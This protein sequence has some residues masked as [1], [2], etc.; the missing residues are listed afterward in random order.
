MKRSVLE[1]YNWK[2]ILGFVIPSIL[3]V[4]LFMIPVEVDGTWTVIVK[5]IADLI[6]SCMADFLPI[7]CCI[8]VTISAVLGVAALF[9]PKFIDEHP[10]MYNTF[11]TTPAWVIIRVIGAV[12]AWI[13]FAGVL[14]GDGEPLQIIGGEDTGTFVLGDLLTVLVIIFFLADC[15]CLFFSISVFSS[16]SEHFLPRSC[17]L[18]SKSLVEVLSTV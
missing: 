14:V 13:A 11:S 4:V 2:H 18:F 10:L 6:G 7:L 8:I 17:V 15:S 16:L 12:F 5:V 9:H 3:G 1:K